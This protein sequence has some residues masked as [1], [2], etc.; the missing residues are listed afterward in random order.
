MT[1]VFR[2]VGCKTEDVGSPDTICDACYQGIE[3]AFTLDEN[4]VRTVRIEVRLGEP[5][6]FNPVFVSGDHVKFGV[7][8]KGYE[9]TPEW[10]AKVLRLLADM[11]E[12]P[13]SPL[14]W[15]KESF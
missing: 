7:S 12:R 3:D 14:P 2:C 9:N 6:G 1:D 11:L 8:V 13:A 4:G 10:H 5:E 15:D